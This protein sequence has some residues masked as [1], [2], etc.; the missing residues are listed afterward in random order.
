MDLIEEHNEMKSAFLEKEKI[1]E[2]K[3]RSFE[4][5]KSKWRRD[6]NEVNTLFS[7]FSNFSTIKVNLLLI[8]KTTCSKSSSPLV[9]SV[10]F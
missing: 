4:A 7:N 1:Y 6:Y 3:I 5:A 2:D 8:V 10:V 9:S